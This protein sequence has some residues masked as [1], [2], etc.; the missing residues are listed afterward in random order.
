MSQS[1]PTWQ[2]LGEMILSTPT[3]RKLQAEDAE[4][5]RGHGPAHRSSKLRL[6]EASEKEI[7]VKLYR[8]SAAWCPYCQKL[9]ILLEEKKVPYRVELINMRSYG[10]K[11][12]SFLAKC[13]RGLLP[14]VEL[15]GKLYTESLDIMAMLDQEFQGP[16]HRPLLPQRSSAAFKKLQELLQLERSLFSAWCSY[17]FRPGTTGR[18]QFEKTLQAVEN[19]LAENPSVPWFLDFT[20][21]PSLVDLQ[22]VSHVER[23]LASVPYWKGHDFRALYPN[24]DKWL[25]AFEKRQCYMA[26]KSDWY[27]HVKDIPPQYGPGVAVP[28]AASFQEALDG[29]DASWQLPLPPLAESTAPSD[30]LQRHGWEPYEATAPH[31][32]AYRLCMN[33]KA[34]VGFMARGAGTPGGWADGRPDR[35][36]LA[37][38]YAKSAGGQAAADA[39]LVLRAVVVLLLDGAIPGEKHGALLEGMQASPMRR[40]DMVACAQYLCKRVGVP[41]D[42][43]YPAARC[44]RGALNWAS[45]Q[46]SNL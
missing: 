39:D 8:D 18:A 4:R 26:T 34:V 17:V 3:G 30:I 29:G 7:R 28:S 31:E 42:M 23:M 14:A 41:R 16:S 9:W 5:E 33:H 21:G 38:P 27:T 11:P 12:K 13:P 44:L 45:A 37:D 25:A 19:A 46:A 1:I 15:D 22:Y 36:E 35:A 20:D 10:D 40:R 43:S 2:Q 6:F 32:A 24:I